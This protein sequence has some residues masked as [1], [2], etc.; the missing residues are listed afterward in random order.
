[1]AGERFL[2]T[3]AMGCLGAWTAKLLL[4]EA[5]DAVVLFD[6][7]TETRRLRLLLPDDARRRAVLVA[8][9]LTD[10]T[11]VA[12]VVGEHG[13]THIVHLAALQV[14]FCRA[15]PVGGARVN[16]VGTVNVFE[17]VR[18]HAE[19]VRGIA[20]ASSA[21]VFGPP[22]LY[23]GGV[24]PDEGPL[25]P[26]TLYGAYKQCNE[27][28]AR[29]YAADHGVRSVGL[30]PCTVYGPGRDQG[31]TSAPTMAMLAAAAGVPYRIMF[32][33]ATTFQHAADAARDFIAAARRAPEGAPVVNCGGEAAAIDEVVAAIHDVVPASRHLIGAA[34]DPLPFPERYASDGIRALLGPLPYRPLRAGI[35]ESIAMF[36][37][38]LGRGLLAPPAA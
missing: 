37:D 12:R 22:S 11:A 17:A 16:V 23:P 38:L 27:G 21:A 20:Y 19:H 15:D 8:G 10:V 3:G 1:M 26:A 6:L 29:V 30:R 24:A 36:R 14:P 31:L 33:G 13:I 4:E 9:D 2:V 25:A 28:T 32:R 35:G 18:A 7:S 5:V 34:G